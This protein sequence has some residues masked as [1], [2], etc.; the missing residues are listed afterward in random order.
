MHTNK[1]P[2]MFNNLSVLGEGSSG[3]VYLAE[4]I[5]YWHGLEPG[6]R[7]AIKVY[8]DE[9]FEREQNVSVIKRRIREANSQSMINHPNIVKVYDTSEF[10]N[11]DQ[12]TF[13]VMEYLDG[14]CLESF[15]QSNPMSYDLIVS[16]AYQLS[17]GLKCLHNNDILHRDI[18][19][20]NVQICSD[21]RAVILDLGVMKQDD[22][23][24]FTSS[25]A[26]LGTLR[27]APPEWLFR[28]EC[29]KASDIYSLGAVFYYLVHGKHIYS[30][31]NLFSRLVVAIK[32]MTIDYD[33]ISD[34]VVIAYMIRM[35]ALMLSKEAIDRPTINDVIL[36]F[37]K[38]EE[39]PIWVSIR[40]S[41]LGK[42]F[43]HNDEISIVKEAGKLFSNEQIDNAIAFNMLEV[44][45]ANPL[46]VAT[47]SLDY[48][49]EVRKG[50]LL[51][52]KEER[53]AWIKTIYEYLDTYLDE[54]EY[55]TPAS[56][57]MR[58]YRSHIAGAIREFETDEMIL[59]EYKQLFDEAIADEDQIY[60]EIRHEVDGD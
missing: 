28:D 49:P 21:G 56:L 23:K 46:F 48:E 37:E 15:V 57:T 50:Y 11:D 26:F 34:N 20:G 5:S 10:W 51:L 12:P 44:L 6:S 27:F 35:T 43:R 47:L 16:I 53:S 4:T 18:K 22:E 60:D 58:C 40:C 19:P 41:I 29:V 17:N 13:I 32:E 14:Q 59:N 38:K 30:E 8:K 52:P 55:E 42:V 36:F 39:S 3:I 24:T 31:I 33:F 54:Q 25:Q 1:L 9:I 45:C 2:N 7:V